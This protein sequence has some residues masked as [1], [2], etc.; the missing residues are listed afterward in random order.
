MLSAL[1]YAD[2]GLRVFPVPPGTKQSHKSAEHSGG[3]KWGATTDD[4]EIKRDFTRWPEAGVG[5]PTGAENGFWI[6]EADTLEGGH[7]FDGVAS[8]RA[9]E[10]EH[11]ALPA[12]RQARSPSGS[13][14]YYFRYPE[15]I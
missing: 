5:I 7:K 15:G 12:T 6:L 3:R 4:A 8:L 13:I 11:G 2:R 1:H 14:H 9:L 10:A